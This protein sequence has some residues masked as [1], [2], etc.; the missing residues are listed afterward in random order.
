MSDLTADEPYVPKD[1]DIAAA[2]DALRPSRS[3]AQRAEVLPAKPPPKVHEGKSQLERDSAFE[4][5]L[6]AID[7]K[8]DRGEPLTEDEADYMQYRAL[9]RLLRSRRPAMVA[10]AVSLLQQARVRKLLERSG[11]APKPEDH[12]LALPGSAS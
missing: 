5:K 4:T 10:R 11:T 8:L 9:S 6:Q 2:V 1:E 12:G 7:E 3:I